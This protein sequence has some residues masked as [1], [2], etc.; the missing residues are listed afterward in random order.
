MT[1]KILSALSRLPMSVLHVLATCLGFVAHRVLKYRRQVI[2]LNIE[3][4][5]PN[6]PTA[7]HRNVERN[8]YKHFA[9][10]TMESIKNFSIS[11]EEAMDRMQH[12]HVELFKPFFHSNRSVL[13]AGGH[14][15]NWELYAV[16]ASQNLDHDVMAVYKKLSDPKMDEAVRSSRERFG[17]E[18]VRTVD[19][20]A[21]MKTHM[22]QGKPKAVV[23]GFDQS[24]A[25]PKKS[26]WNEFLSQ[27]TAWYF[28]LE[29][30]AHEFNLPVIYGH[31]YKVGR[32]KY[33]TEYELITDDPKSLPS[34][35]I[36][37]RCIRSLEIDIQNHPDEWLWSH[38]RWKH[39]RPSDA[40]LNKSALAKN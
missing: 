34:G 12:Q 23:M 35:E 21:W 1:A 29:K 27:E 30:W 6:R 13:I 31:I 38:K 17:L 14:L 9:D 3:Q 2:R 4:S 18:M 39:V 26:W 16:T 28:G 32:G 36:L 19:S 37:R 20:Q 11:N 10:I 7:W 33:R 5:F 22:G 40:Q 24:P 8:Y 25:D 15:N